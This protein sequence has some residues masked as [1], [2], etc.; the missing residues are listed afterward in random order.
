MAFKIRGKL[1][2]ESGKN[3]LLR[4]VVN[5]LLGFVEKLAFKIRGKL[6]RKIGLRIVEKLVRKIGLRIVEKL[7]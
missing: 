6:V 1:A 2:L 5:W 7:V 4:F 3:W